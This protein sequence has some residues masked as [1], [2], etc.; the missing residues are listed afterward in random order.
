MVYVPF[1]SCVLSGRVC[2]RW[3]IHASATPL[4]CHLY[5]IHVCLRW[6][7]HASAT[8]LRCVLCV[9]CCL[10]NVTRHVRRS[11]SLFA[12]AT[13]LM[14]CLNPS[15]SQKCHAACMWVIVPSSSKS[16]MQHRVAPRRLDFCS[17]GVV[18]CTGFDAP[19][20]LDFC[21]TGVGCWLVCG[22][23]LMLQ[24]SS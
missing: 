13:P 18:F 4:V 5:S 8:P 16:V 10:G 12:S 3:R 23:G 11:W 7:I 21:S 15:S 2:L 14:C 17:T 24:H 6:R 20:R 22:Q 9:P 1:L 19:R